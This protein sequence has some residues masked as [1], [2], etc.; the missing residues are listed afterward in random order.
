MADKKY[1]NEKG[2]ADLYPYILRPQN[3]HLSFYPCSKL[4]Y[5]PPL[6]IIPFLGNVL[7]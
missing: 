4:G 2:C 5:F 1:G 7:E 3:P 6:N